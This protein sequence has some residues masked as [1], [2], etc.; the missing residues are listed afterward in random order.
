MNFF[1]GMVKS[2]DGR[3]VFEEG[4]LSPSADSARGPADARISGPR[5]SPSPAGGAK[6]ASG[7]GFGRVGELTLPGNGFRLLI[8]AHVVERL[9]G[10]DSVGRHVVLGVRPEHL[11]LRPTQD[12]E[13]F[14]PLTMRVNVIEPLGSNMD[15]YLSTNLS[16]PVVARVEAQQGLRVDS[17]ATLYVDLRKVHFFGPGDAGMN[18]SQTSEPIHALA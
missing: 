2:I 16:D 12:G 7:A 6:T 17:Q 11:Y 4:R 3:A 1:D 5:G 14:A 8:P 15:V 18:L 13:L 10:A 9:A